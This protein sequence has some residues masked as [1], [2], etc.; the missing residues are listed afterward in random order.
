MQRGFYLYSLVTMKYITPY[1][2][3]WPRMF[4]RI[5]RFL[6]WALPGTCRIHHVGSTAIAG[7]PAKDIIDIDIECP[8]N[9]M[10]VLIEH[11]A[12]AGYIHEGDKGI[13]GREAF[14]PRSEGPAARLPGHHLYACESGS[15]ELARHLAFRDYLASHG[16]RAKWLAEEKIASDRLADSREA[17]IEAKAA[18]YA[19][20]MEEAL[21]W[22]GKT[23]HQ[24]RDV[25]S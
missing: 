16:Q 24:G 21:L 7:M 9:M 10:S 13:A 19:L 5:A 4:E 11:L 8:G 17:Y 14:R 1:N 23:M 25:I 3:D 22:A 20:V 12:G 2:L 15:S 6:G 18:A